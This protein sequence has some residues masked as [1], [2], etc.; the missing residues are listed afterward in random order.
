M[1]SKVCQNMGYIMHKNILYIFC[2]G[3]IEKN[4]LGIG[5]SRVALLLV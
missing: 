3:L 2:Q 5:F 1:Y 4:D